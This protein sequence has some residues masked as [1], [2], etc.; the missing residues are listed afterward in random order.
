M[1]G[2]GHSA[3]NG[4]LGACGAPP[5][6]AGSVDGPVS[7]GNGGELQGGPVV[8]Y[9]VGQCGKY[10][11]GGCTDFGQRSSWSTCCEGVLISDW[12]YAHSGVQELSDRF[13]LLDFRM[14]ERPMSMQQSVRVG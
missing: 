2:F 11:V 9:A 10:E 5:G 8:A 4:M 3:A 6:G 7:G 14:E 1:A 12:V 13:T